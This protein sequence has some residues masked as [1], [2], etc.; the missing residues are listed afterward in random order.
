MVGRKT[1]QT[2]ASSS[3]SISALQRRHVG[4]L[5]IVAIDRNGARP[6]PLRCA[7]GQ[8]RRRR[9]NIHIPEEVQSTHLIL[10]LLLLLLLLVACRRRPPHSRTSAHGR[11]HVQHLEP[12]F[13]KMILYYI[14][15][16]VVNLI[17]KRV[18]RKIILFSNW[19][20]S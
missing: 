2:S 10:L 11:L 4:L 15:T 14:K 16:L 13:F 7:G 18:G 3:T 5:A 19:T 1:G 20:V 6:L 8:H 9:R 12:T 17:I